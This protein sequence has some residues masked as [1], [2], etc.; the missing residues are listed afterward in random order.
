MYPGVV[1][2]GVRLPLRSSSGFIGL[3]IS[4]PAV[5]MS[6]DVITTHIPTL[7]KVAVDIADIFDRRTT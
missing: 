1:G 4:A 3:C 2:C 7:R 6:Y 5:R